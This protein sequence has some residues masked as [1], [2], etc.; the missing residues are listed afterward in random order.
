LT[1]SDCNNHSIKYDSSLTYQ[2]IG[3]ED[4]DENGSELGEFYTPIGIDVNDKYMIVNDLGNQRIQLF[5]R[6]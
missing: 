1:L 3:R 6:R 4:S 5:R 2:Y